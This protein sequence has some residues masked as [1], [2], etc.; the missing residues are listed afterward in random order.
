MAMVTQFFMFPHSQIHNQRFG[1]RLNAAPKHAEMQAHKGRT[2]GP[3]INLRI[4]CR[5]YPEMKG[6]LK[7]ILRKRLSGGQRMMAK[8]ARD[9][10]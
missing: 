4:Q 10:M 8:S 1:D 7:E 2:S 3:A 5:I 9:V 6:E